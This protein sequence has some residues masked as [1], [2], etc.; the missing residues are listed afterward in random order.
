MGH[1]ASLSMTLHDALYD[2]SGAVSF[3]HLYHVI[4]L[5]VL[6]KCNVNFVSMTCNSVVSIVS[7]CCRF[8]VNNV[9]I[10]CEEERRIF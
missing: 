6:C 9:S 3:Q 2:V 8:C 5:L 4:V 1:V 10:V 7:Q